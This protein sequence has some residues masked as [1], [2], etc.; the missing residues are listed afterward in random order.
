MKK[1]F[2]LQTLEWVSQYEIIRYVLGR[3][4]YTEIVAL[5]DMEKGIKFCRKYGTLPGKD[6]KD[7][8]KMALGDKIIVDY[9]GFYRK[10][11]FVICM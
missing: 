11:C 7:C 4:R 5:E 2:M 9:L 3:L 8:S 10:V 6:F 1:A